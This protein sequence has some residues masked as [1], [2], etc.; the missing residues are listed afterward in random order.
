MKF[1]LAS[2]GG[3]NPLDK[4]GY[5]ALKRRLRSIDNVEIHCPWEHEPN[6]TLGVYTVGKM[7]A[8]AIIKCDGLIAVCNGSDVDSGT[9]AE[10]GYAYGLRKPTMGF[11]D[12]LRAAHDVPGGTINAQVQFFL[13]SGLV[14]SLDLFCQKLEK[15]AADFEK[16]R[17]LEGATSG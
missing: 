14:L 12:D 13:S 8:G 5:E 10:I 2:P 15:M 1:Y 11:R 3:F 17:R 7:N 16:G 4:V 9:A 6:A